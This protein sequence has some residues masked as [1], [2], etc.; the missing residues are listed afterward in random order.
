[1]TL[2]DT[3]SAERVHIGFF[4]ATNAGKSSLVNRVTGQSMSLVSAVSGTTTDPVKKAMELLPL[5]PVV[6]VDTPGFDDESTL[7]QMRVERTKKELQKIDAA[8]LVCDSQKGITKT[9]EELIEILKQNKTAYII[10]YSKA[11][12]LNERKALRDNEIYVSAQSGENIDALKEKLARIIPQKSNKMG[13]VDS[14]IKKGDTVILVTP[15][16]EAAPKGRIILPQ[17]QVLRNI[18]DI[19]AIACVCQVEEL[20]ALLNN[21]KTKPAAVITDSQAFGVVSKIVPD[22]IPLTSFSILLANYR[23]MLDAAVKGVLA[24]NT[25]KDGD[26]ILIAEGCTHHRQCNDIGSVKI[27]NWIR[28]H[29]EKE[30]R[31]DVV[32]GHEFPE[33]LKEYSLILHCG[34]CMITE[35]EVD[36]RRKRAQE[37]NIPFTNYGITIAY[38]HGILKRSLEV[39]PELYR[40]L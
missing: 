14:F 31:F 15:I 26:K 2:N 23:G 19:G 25:L 3:P 7:G 13:I 38:I 8:V 39:F 4:G 5:G 9:D 34:G 21:L 29:T 32:S 40:K 6:I 20:G 10:A 16:D 18:L 17:Q 35:R 24:I 12:L 28:K 22:D 36:V 37:Q 27:P 1:M 11:D 30:I 33:N